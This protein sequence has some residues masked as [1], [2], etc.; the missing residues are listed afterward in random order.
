MRG[1][2]ELLLALPDYRQWESRPQRLHGAIGALLRMLDEEPEAVRRTL[3][4]AS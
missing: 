1:S 4:A 3:L 2:K